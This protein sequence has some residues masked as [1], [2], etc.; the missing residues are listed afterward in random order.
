[1]GKPQLQGKL[2]GLL[3]AGPGCAAGSVY[4]YKRRPG[5]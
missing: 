3:S 2:I 5:G 1:M 4:R